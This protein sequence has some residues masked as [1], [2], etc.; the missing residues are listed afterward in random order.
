[1]D[2]QHLVHFRDFL[3]IL[4]REMLGRVT[5]LEN[6]IHETVEPVIE[7]EEEAQRAAATLPYDRLTENVKGTIDQI[8]IAINKILTGEYGICEDCRQD[9]S[10]KRLEA[11]PWTHLCIDC[12]R[13]LE[14]SSHVPEPVVESPAIGEL[15][16]EYQGLSNNQ[17]L[18]IVREQIEKDGRIDTEELDISLR[19]KVLYL[20]G[21][22]AGEPEHQILL[23]I[24]MDVLGFSELIDHLEVNEVPFERTDRT[25]GKTSSL[26]GLTLEDR[27]FYDEEDLSEDLFEAGDE[28]PYHPPES[29]PPQEYILGRD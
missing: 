10:L 7:P 20:E 29:P 16:D 28:K 19:D 3:L 6:R 12:A 18:S 14:R 21:T 5:D 13:D 25:P 24:M 4:R 23:Q 1:M 26:Y 27:I 17:I 9:I 2:R 8:D 15:P 22:V 11:L